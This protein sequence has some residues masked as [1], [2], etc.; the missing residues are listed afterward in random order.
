MGRASTSAAGASGDATPPRRIIGYYAG[1]TAKTKNYTPLDIPADKLTHVNYAFGL[2][3]ADGKAMLGDAEADIGHSDVAASPHLGSLKGN[4]HQ[5]GLLKER[6]PHVRTLI[7]IGGWT[8]S[9]RFSD[10]V[11][12]EEKRRAF[13]GSCIALF[14]TRWPGVFD[15][16]D[17]DWEYPVCCGLPD[18]AYRPE[19]RRNCTLL[20]AEFRRQLDGLGAL[21]GRHF[22][23]TA[24]MPAGRELPTGCFEPREAAHI[25][26]WINVMTYDMNGSKRS[27]IT[28]FNAPFRPSSSDPRPEETRRDWSVEG[29]VRVFEEAG[30]PREQIVVGVP[31]YGHGFTGVPDVNN[32]LYQSFAEPMS[33]DYHTIVS[34][35][36]PLPTFEQF[37]DPEAEVPWLYDAESQTM[38]SYDD[39]ESIARKTDYVNDQG[40]GGMMF[41]ELSGDDKEASLLTAISTRLKP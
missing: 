33:A 4:F 7:S 25:L 8:G 34:D 32:G 21:T 22:L 30:V 41:W 38:L 18:N 26:D 2:I 10:A 13:A 37:R 40:L 1:W 3:D 5:L 36:L 17:I 31:F 23:L 29:T 24:A 12:T 28:N 20:F 39:P 11:A 14:I 15:G 16:I 27:G 6:Y 19:D 9:G 35:L